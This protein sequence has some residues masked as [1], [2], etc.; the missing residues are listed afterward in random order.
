M[1][2][3]D[4]RSAFI[5]ALVLALLIRVIVAHWRNWGVAEWTRFVGHLAVSIGMVSLALL[6]AGGAALHSAVAG[7]PNSLWRTLYA[8]VNIILALYGVVSGIQVLISSTGDAYNPALFRGYLHAMAIFALVICFA[9]WVASLTNT[10]SSR[11]G[12]VVIGGFLLWLGTAMPPWV[13]AAARGSPVTSI[14]SQSGVRALYAVLGVGAI[15]AGVIG[16]P[17]W[18]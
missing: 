16:W 9:L 15:G 3:L 18:L 10:S 11:I 6:L 2:E 1:D 7:P 8:F 13:E 5:A 14:L 12:S 4:P 17:R